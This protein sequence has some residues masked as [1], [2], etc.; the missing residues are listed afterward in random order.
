M[1]YAWEEIK[2]VTYRSEIID[3]VEVDRLY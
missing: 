2:E 1:V 3:G